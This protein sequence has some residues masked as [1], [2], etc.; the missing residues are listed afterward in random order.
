M[1]EKWYEKYQRSFYWSLSTMMLIGSKGN[2]FLESWFTTITILLTVGVFAY[3]ISQISNIIDDINKDTSYYKNEL[4]VINKYMK[5]KNTSMTIQSKIRNYL[6]FHHQYVGLKDSKEA[7]SEVLNKIPSNLKDQLYKESYKNLLNEFPIIK[8]RFSQTVLDELVSVMEENVYLTDEIIFQ[9]NQIDNLALYLIH[10]GK[11]SLMLYLSQRNILDDQEDQV[12][13]QQNQKIIKLCE[14]GDYFGTTDQQYLYTSKCLEPCTIFKIKKEDF[15][16]IVRKD[17]LELEKYKKVKDKLFFERGICKLLDQQCSLC[18]SLT[19]PEHKCPYPHYQI[20][21]VKLLK[22]TYSRP[23]QKRNPKFK[24]CK[25]GQDISKSIDQGSSSWYTH[26]DGIKF[27]TNNGLY[28]FNKRTNKSISNLNQQNLNPSMIQIQVQ[29]ELASPIGYNNMDGSI[30]VQNII[31][32]GIFAEN[33]NF[34]NQNVEFQKF[35]ARMNIQNINSMALLFQSKLQQQIQHF[36]DT[37]VFQSKTFQQWKENFLA[38]QV[39]QYQNEDSNWYMIWLD[40]YLVEQQVY[41]EDMIEDDLAMETHSE[42]LNGS[43]SDIYEFNGKN[44]FQQDYQEDF[45]KNQAYKNQ[46]NRLVTNSCENQK[47]YIVNERIKEEQSMEDFGEENFQNKNNKNEF[48]FYDQQQNNYNYTQKKSSIANT[49]SML[50]S[51]TNKS[52]LSFMGGL[53]RK[54]KERKKSNAVEFYRARKKNITPFIYS[55]TDEKSN[56][57]QQ[58]QHQEKKRYQI[59]FVVGE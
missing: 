30:L 55:L 6:E 41:C 7:L 59:K 34:V 54:N 15:E 49:Q 27:D 57:N 22:L 17:P 12:Q 20:N 37:Q 5:Q 14:K 1:D 10:Q 28:K 16:K 45:K 35:N 47:S 46:L 13:K 39:V 36:M 38:N 3:T 43:D 52:Q 31:Q 56:F 42:S 58:T 24:R 11:V 48:S 40:N 23:H 32:N 21:S 18:N 29:D 9:Q 26:I 19:H 44:N 33:T 2:N 53:G 50:Q 25:K 8:N 51:E 4:S